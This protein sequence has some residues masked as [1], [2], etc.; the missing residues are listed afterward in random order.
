MLGGTLIYRN[1]NGKTV[2]S[3]RP[4]YKNETNTEARRQA[5]GKFRE[6]ANFAGKAM[7]DSKLKAYYMQKAKQ[8]KLPNAYTAAITD[9]LR[10]AK[11]RAMTRSTFAAKKNDSI[12]IK[13]NKGVFAVKSIRVSLCDTDGNV[14]A[15]QTLTKLSRGYTFVFPDDFPAFSR[16]KIVTG[17]P[18]ENLHIIGRDEIASVTLR[19]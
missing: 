8:L 15:E 7:E 6:A 16:L 4:V 18:E 9:F 10:K 11:V 17:E 5:R 1:Y 12:I 19:E 3:L 14:L 13:V 2:V